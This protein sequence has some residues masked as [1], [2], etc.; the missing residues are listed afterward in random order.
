MGG[1]RQG[2]VLVNIK[3]SAGV[4]AGV[5]NEESK[6]LENVLRCADAEPFS[7]RHRVRPRDFVSYTSSR[8]GQGPYNLLP[9]TYSLR[10]MFLQEAEAIGPDP[11]QEDPR[12]DP[13]PQVAH[14]VREYGNQGQ[15]L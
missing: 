9:T 4:S 3:S 7:C 12:E 5:V 11:L 8:V 13:E 2:V 15:H 1:Q 6:N 14:G 10:S